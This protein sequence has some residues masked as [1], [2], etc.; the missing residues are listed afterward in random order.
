MVEDDL[1]EALASGSIAGAALDVAP[2]EP[3]P[4]DSR[5]WSVANVVMTPHTAGASQ[6]RAARNMDRF[7][8]NIG[9][10]LGGERLAGVIDKELG[11]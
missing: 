8:G 5:L 10:F 2:R 1:V 4:S 9:R 6:F 3:L 11:Y 7:V